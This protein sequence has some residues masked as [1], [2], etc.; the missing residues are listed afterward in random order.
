MAI[1]QQELNKYLKKLS[2]LSLDTKNSKIVCNYSNKFLD[3]DK[4]KKVRKTHK[5]PLSPDMLFIHHESQEVWFV[6]FKSSTRENLKHK[7]FEIKRKILDGLIIFYEIFQKYYEFKKYYFVVY[8]TQESYEDKVLN[9]FSEKGI[10]FDLE[11]I[12]GKFLDKVFTNSSEN[13]IEKWQ[14]RF[15]IEFIKEK[16]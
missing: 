9:G 5:L 12:E 3:F 10:E 7:K 14:E 11:E 2:E 15:G 16:N 13:F 1:A 8:D 4:L 6:E